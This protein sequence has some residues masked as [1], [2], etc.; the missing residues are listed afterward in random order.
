M[1]PFRDISI[2][3]K[4]MVMA[5]FKCGMVLLVSITPLFIFQI[6]NFRTTFERDTAVLAAI[7][8]GNSAK[9]QFFEHFYTNSSDRFL[10]INQQYICFS[11]DRQDRLC[12]NFL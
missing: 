12:F 7:I 1:K 8:G 5:L 6:W 9:A 4:L 3:K 2:D 10:I 11:F